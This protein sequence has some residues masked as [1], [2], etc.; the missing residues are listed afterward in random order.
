MAEN[1]LNIV[2]LYL[3]FTMENFR[4]VSKYDIGDK[5]HALTLLWPSS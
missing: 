1:Q 4:S 2:G 5:N 3:E